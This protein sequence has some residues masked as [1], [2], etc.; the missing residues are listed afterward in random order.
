[1]AQLPRTDLC[2]PGSPKPHLDSPGLH[3]HCRK[4]GARDNKILYICS[5]CNLSFFIEIE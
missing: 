1:M 4:K 5:V 2:L 3:P